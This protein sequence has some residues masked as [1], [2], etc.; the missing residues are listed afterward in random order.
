[1]HGLS[2]TGRNLSKLDDGLFASIYSH[3]E[4]LS[5]FVFKLFAT[6]LQR[7]TRIACVVP[8]YVFKFNARY[9]TIDV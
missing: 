3:E 2:N 9:G 5:A 8:S 6:E 1:M 4:Q 7:H